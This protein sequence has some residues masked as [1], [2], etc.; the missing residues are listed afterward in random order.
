MNAEEYGWLE[1]FLSMRSILVGGENAHYFFFTS[2][3][4]YCK[5]LNQYFQEAW[6]G[7]GLPGTPTFTAVRSSIATHVSIPVLVSDVYV[8]V[9]LLPTLHQCFSLAIQA[10][11]THCPDDWYKVAKFMCYDTSTADRFY[12]LNLNAKQTAEHRRLLESA[13]K[14]EETT[15]VKKV[16]TWKRPI[17]SRQKRA[18]K[19]AARLSS[20]ADCI[21]SPP[22]KINLM[23]VV[24]LSP[25]NTSQKFQATQKLV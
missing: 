3:P 8:C 4:S 13:V 2:K 10:K 17:T 7:M 14:G 19:R 18:C 22:K 9:C 24:Q 5:N 16:E 15:P 25:M 12:A 6:A 20:S 23:P 11:N 21:F 1:E